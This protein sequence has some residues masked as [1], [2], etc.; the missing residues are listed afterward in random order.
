MIDKNTYDMKAVA[1]NIS[2]IVKG[3][4]E[5]EN[6]PM[7]DLFY[8]ID[9]WSYDKYNY[10]VRRNPKAINDEFLNMIMGNFNCSLKDITKGAK[11]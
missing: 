1:A 3:K 10:Y 2:A 7:Y 5:K 9:D 8:D 11:K 4:A 6:R